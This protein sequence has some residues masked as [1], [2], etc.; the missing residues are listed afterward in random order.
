[1]NRSQHI[2]CSI[3]LIWIIS[4]FQAYAADV[5]LV[6]INDGST[7]KEFSAVF[8]FTTI[9]NF[10]ITNN[11]T[12]KVVLANGRTVSG[13][14]A[15]IQIVVEYLSTTDDLTVPGEAI[16]LLNSKIE[17][18]KRVSKM[19]EYSRPYLAP[20]IKEAQA[21]LNQLNL[22]LVRYRNSWIE[23]TTYKILMA[24]QAS[25]QI[26]ALTIAGKTFT[27]VKVI[28]FTDGVIAVS[29]EGGMAKLKY[30]ELGFES[31][32]QLSQISPL[33]RDN[34]D[35]RE[36]YGQFLPEFATDGRTYRGVRVLSLVGEKLAITSENGDAVLAFKNLSEAQIAALAVKSSLVRQQLEYDKKKTQRLEQSESDFES[37]ISAEKDKNWPKARA[38]YE[39][40]SQAGHKQA[41]VNL[42][43]LVL[44]GRGG[45]KD[46]SKLLNTF[47]E[48]SSQGDPVA[49]F[50]A[51]LLRFQRL[52]PGSE[53]SECAALFEQAAANDV[54]QAH[55]FLGVMFANGIGISQN[56]ELSRE[57][58]KK[59][60]SGGVE[61][62]RQALEILQEV[63]M[64]SK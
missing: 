31:L 57:H 15:H 6:V 23:L 13:L 5:G 50:N 28:G 64:N 41:A 17:Q 3:A 9:A 27:K 53:D 40:A 59:A 48:A 26:V 30:T 45:I 51:G 58:L 7:S 46:E 49:A 4:S 29:H 39:S 18:M 52:R 54:A 36:W 38:L 21:M 25:E 19:Y 20:R 1:M 34:K 42:A 44:E 10:S 56:I 63:T 2:F 61:E 12:Y 24:K 8:E 22:G 16:Q 43:A 47:T 32:R 14:A 11:S 55:Y 62:A 33:I 60:L 35:I 37:A